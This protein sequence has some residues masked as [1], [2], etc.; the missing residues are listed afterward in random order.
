MSRISI[1][2]PIY[3]VENYIRQSL[4][5]LINQTFKDIE[6]ICV[7]DCSP[8]NSVSIIKEYA[9]NDNRIKLIELEQ[10]AGQGNARNVGIEASTSE[11]IMFLDPDD[12][13]EIDACEKAYNQI[14]Q[15]NNEFVVFDFYRYYEERNEKE[16]DCNFSKL[17]DTKLKSFNPRE[18]DF[19][20]LTNGFTWN[21]SHISKQLDFKNPDNVK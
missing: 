20:F 9:K 15:N 5:S 19:Q 3:N 1:I 21:K 14:T 13:F 17:F 6:I 11:Y 18:C 10:N 2:L 16:I 12:W 4:D 7:D 8:D